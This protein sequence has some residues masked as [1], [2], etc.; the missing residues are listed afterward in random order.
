MDY[1]EALTSLR[2]VTVEKIVVADLFR[3]Q[4]INHFFSAQSAKLLAVLWKNFGFSAKPSRTLRLRKSGDRRPKTEVGSK[5]GK[6]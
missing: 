2:K 6:S 5:K 1:N 4:K 3:F